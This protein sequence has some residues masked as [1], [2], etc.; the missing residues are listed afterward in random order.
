LS[1]LNDHDKKIERLNNQDVTVKRNKDDAEINFF[2]HMNAIDEEF[3]SGSLNAQSSRLMNPLKNQNY[4][5]DVDEFSTSKNS[6]H[7]TNR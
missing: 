5:N 3:E 4:K 7:K 6:T 2:K 1:D